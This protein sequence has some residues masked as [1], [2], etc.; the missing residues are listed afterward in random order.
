MRQARHGQLRLLGEGGGR[1]LKA[2]GHQVVPD[3]QQQLLLREGDLGLGHHAGP[4]QPR[5]RHVGADQQRLSG[6]PLDQLGGKL[7]ELDVLAALVLQHR[8]LHELLDVT[9]AEQRQLADDL[10]DGAGAGQAH[11]SLAGQGSDL[12]RIRDGHLHRQQGQKHLQREKNCRNFEVKYVM[13]GD[14]EEETA[15]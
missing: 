5:Q 7:A 14:L 10:A 4:L 6:D 11:Q 8:L 1:V 2:L 15:T 3:E 12:V 13:F 9:A